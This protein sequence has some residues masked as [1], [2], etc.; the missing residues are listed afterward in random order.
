MGIVINTELTAIMEWVHSSIFE[1]TI[2]ERSQKKSF[3]LA[4]ISH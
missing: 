4:R 2:A 1:K 3:L